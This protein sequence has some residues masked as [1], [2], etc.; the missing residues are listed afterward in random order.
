MLHLWKKIPK[1]L[2]MIQN[3]R[4]VRDHCHYTGR[5]KGAAH[6]ICNL[7]FNAPNEVPVVFHNDSNYDYQ[8]IIKELANEFEGKFECLGENT[9][10]YKTYSVPIEKEV[11]NTDKDGNESVYNISYKIKFIDSTRFMGSLLSNLVDN[12]AEGIHKIK[13]KDCDCFLESKSDKDNFI[14][15]KCL[16]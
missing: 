11:S 3:Y 9:E 1:G 6:S 5:Y 13:C 7:K 12:L 16:S 15:Y 8:F 14:K 4:K 2:L 10:K